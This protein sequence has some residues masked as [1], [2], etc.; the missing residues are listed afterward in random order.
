M[1]SSCIGEKSVGLSSPSEHTPKTE[2]SCANKFEV[3]QLWGCEVPQFE[4]GCCRQCIKIPAALREVSRAFSQANALRHMD[5]RQDSAKRPASGV[6]QHPVRWAMEKDVSVQGGMK[7]KAINSAL[8]LPDKLR[9]R[10][11]LSVGP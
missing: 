8:R 10:R 6:C 1:E 2:G 7:G 11:D 9:V 5:M 4:A 3:R